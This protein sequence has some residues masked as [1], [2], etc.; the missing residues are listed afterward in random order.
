MNELATMAH[1]FKLYKI[2]FKYCWKIIITFIVLNRS[3]P[4]PRAEQQKR[5]E[6]LENEMKHLTEVNASVYFMYLLLHNYYLLYL[7]TI[8]VFL[9]L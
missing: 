8:V 6:R 9:I 1:D 7:F 4:K 3:I 2:I 5:L